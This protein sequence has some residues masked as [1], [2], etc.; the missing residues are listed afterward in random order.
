MTDQP[1][2]VHK[3]GRCM[4]NN[5]AEERAAAALDTEETRIQIQ[6]QGHK[7]ILTL[8]Q[9]S[10]METVTTHRAVF[11]PPKDPGV[12]KRGIRS[13]LLEKHIALMISEKFRAEKNLPQPKTDFSST[14]Q[15]DF[16]AD[17]FVPPTPEPTED[18]DYKSDEAITFWSE[19]RHQIQGVT[20]VNNLQAPFRKSAK[21]STPISERLDEPEPLPDD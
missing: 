16:C 12:R 9:D 7:G 8:A 3:V 20:A 2:S 1:V 19:N 17:G 11:I 15:R 13:E 14:T 4:L 6:R 18:Y 5:W 21:F 10:T